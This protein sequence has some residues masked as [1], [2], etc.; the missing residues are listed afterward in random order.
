MIKTY[1]EM[2]HFDTFEDRY[3]YLKLNGQVA[4]ETFGFNRHLNQTFYKS[5]EWQDVRR[6]VILR[7][8]GCDLGVL[9]YD[10]HEE[11]LVHHITPMGVDDIYDRNQA[12][13]DP[14]NLITTTHITHNAIH[15]GDDSL[16]PAAL[17]IRTPG[18]TKLW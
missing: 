4:H 17:V 6:H 12:L 11:L 13:V 8:N 5:R 1:S 9:G 7:D 14:E 18:D 16:L 10:I 3:A 15:Y 2:A